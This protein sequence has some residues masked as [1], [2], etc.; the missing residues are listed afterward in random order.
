MIFFPK[1]VFCV[2]NTFTRCDFVDKNAYHFC[3]SVLR[4]FER[5]YL[6]PDPP[7]CEVNRFFGNEKSSAVTRA[8]L[9]LLSL[10]FTF[11]FGLLLG[12]R[13]LGR[14]CLGFLCF[15]LLL[16]GRRVAGRRFFGVGFVCRFFGVV[17]LGLTVVV[18]VVVAP[19]YLS[20]VYSAP[21]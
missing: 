21:V 19:G 18:V 12:W 15:G 17:A 11:G 7:R 5:A 16:F 10:Q 9:L 13:G 3:Q 8:Y 4:A 2:L 6:H 20:G 14:P 1:I